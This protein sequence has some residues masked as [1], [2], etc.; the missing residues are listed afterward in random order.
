MQYNEIIF[1]LDEGDEWVPPIFYPV[2]ASKLIPEW[3]KK[4][5]S[6]TVPPTNGPERRA[7]PT[8]KRCMPVFD[9]ITSGYLILT[10][11]DIEIFPDGTFGWAN[12]PK[13]AISKH[14]KSQI[15][16]YK[17]KDVSNDM[18]K[19]RNPWGIKTTKGYS[20]LFISPMHRPSTGLE[21]LEGIVDTDNYT[22]SVQFP[23]KVV[24]NFVGTIPAGTPIAQVIPFKRDSWKMKI[25]DE[26]DRKQN[27]DVWMTIMGMWNNGY[28]KLFRE[29]KEY[30]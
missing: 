14:S 8:I 1:T 29:N 6:Y 22:N 17:D 9:S 12:D 10:H 30:L 16:N 27:K 5:E 21:I 25:G 19:F 26:K 7:F 4:I 3:Y 15:Y 24:D 18:P 2:P 11:T 20:C 13:E 28:R 23:M